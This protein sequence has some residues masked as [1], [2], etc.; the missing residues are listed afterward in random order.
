MKIYG[1]DDDLIMSGYEAN[2]LLTYQ[3]LSIMLT[4]FYE[5]RI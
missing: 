4:W 1:A 5:V 2:H 3:W